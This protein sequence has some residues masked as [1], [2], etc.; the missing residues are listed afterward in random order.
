VQLLKDELAHKLHA[1]VQ[2]SSPGMKVRQRP[3]HLT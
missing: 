3:S 2:R 1:A